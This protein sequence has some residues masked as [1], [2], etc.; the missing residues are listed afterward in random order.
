MMCFSHDRVPI[1]QQVEHMAVNHGVKG[2]SPFRDVYITSN[3][4]SRHT[5]HSNNSN[6]H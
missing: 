5:Y 3:Y 4:K 1:A 2:S 6:K